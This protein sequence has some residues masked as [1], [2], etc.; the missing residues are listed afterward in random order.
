[1]KSKLPQA[2]QPSHEA[3]FFPF[4]EF[5]SKGNV[6]PAAGLR[7][8]KGISEANFTV[9][10]SRVRNSNDDVDVITAYPDFGSYCIFQDMITSQRDLVVA[11]GRQLVLK[12]CHEL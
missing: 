12:P 4:L 1:M 8:E 9:V 10:W 11:Y 7:E 2:L 6:L 3:T 5:S